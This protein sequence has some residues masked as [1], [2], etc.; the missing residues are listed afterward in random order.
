MARPLAV[1]LLLDP[2]G[3]EARVHV[4]V[5]LARPVAG[6]AEPVR[7]AGRHHDHL[8][9]AHLDLAVRAAERR[10]ALEHDEDLG[11]F[12]GVQRGASPRSCVHE[13]EGHADAVVVGSFELE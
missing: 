7:L 3:H 13:E 4:D 1:R 11:I 5:H 9:R 8:A 6:R 12:V 2:L 10:L